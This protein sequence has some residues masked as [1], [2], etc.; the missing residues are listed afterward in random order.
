MYVLREF[1]RFH[2][3][4]RLIIQNI[5]EGE[6]QIAH[7]RLFLILL[8]LIHTFFVVYTNNRVSVSDVANLYCLGV[9]LIYTIVLLLLIDKYRVLRVFSYASSTLDVILVTLAIY[10]TQ[11]DPEASV[12]SLTSSAA[13]TVYAPIIIISI[14]RHDPI[15]TIYTGILSALGYLMIIIVMGIKN[16]FEN[17][18]LSETGLLI[19][20]D[21][22]NEIIKVSMLAITGVV[23]FFAA[24][25]FD[26]VFVKALKEEKE[27]EQIRHTFGSYI[28]DEL[29]DRILDNDIPIESETC[30]VTVMFIDIKN[31]TA[32]SENVTPQ[33]L[34]KI[35]NTF[36][37]YCISIIGKYN[38]FID[39]FI[40]DA[41]MVDFGAPIFNERHREDALSCA[42]AIH[43]SSPKLQK[44]IRTLGVDWNLEFGIGIN[45]GDAVLGN[46]GTSQRMEYTALG[47]AVNTASRI[48][49]LT[50]RLD[51]P[52]LV[53]ENTFN[54]NLK[55]ILDEGQI[56][57]LRG[58]TST[59]KVYAAK[60]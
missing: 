11:F 31:F 39:K 43:Q 24:Q 40:G 9:A 33:L 60:L 20:N 47:D 8:L 19:V 57:N 12:A 1:R 46:I 35:L 2:G 32:L 41:I 5:V 7:L 45:S 50:R 54:E 58:K 3:L 6:K 26:R 29:V 25:N 56:V 30:T 53:G 44:L 21:L 23:G 42:I 48:E 4:T 59:V 36:F 16:S 22:S 37:S 14:R 38:G 49:R 51:K 10:M 27:K 13:L 15:N 52:I 17:K 18:L 28:S 55:S 34:V